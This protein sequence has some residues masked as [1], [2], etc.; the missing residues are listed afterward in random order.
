MSQENLTIEYAKKKI[1]KLKK[2]IN[3]PGSIT[4][5]LK[6]D[7]KIFME[8]IEIMYKNGIS[9][10]GCNFFANILKEFL[11]NTNSLITLDCLINYSEIY[12]EIMKNN[13]GSVY[14]KR[15]VLSF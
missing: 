8:F 2:D 14:D 6:F 13:S 1:K 15:G 10:S 3:S 5:E 4:R 11:T 7:P 12:L 9:N